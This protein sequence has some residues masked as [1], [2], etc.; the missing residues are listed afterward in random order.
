MSLSKSPS[1][2]GS[3]GDWTLA[4]SKAAAKDAKNLSAAGLKPKTQALLNLLRT[5]PWQNPPPYEKLVGELAGAYSRR[6]NLQHRL[7]YRVNESVKQ[8]DVLRMW[9]HYE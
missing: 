2:T 1:L 6:I 9:T 8:V 4:F 5:N 7:V 3:V